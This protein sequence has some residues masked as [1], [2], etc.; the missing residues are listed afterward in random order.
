MTTIE[1]APGGGARSVESVSRQCAVA[2]VG[3]GYAGLAAAIE[4]SNILPRELILVFE[5][6]DKPG[7]NSVMNAGQIAVVGSDQQLIA[8]IEDTVELMMDDM[9]RA[10]V[11]LNHPNL[12][13]TMIEQ[14]NETVEWTQSE[15]GVQY[16]TRVTQLGGHSV[17]RTLSTLNACGEDIIGPMI[18]KVDSKDNVELIL[19]TAFESFVMS[20]D[21]HVLGIRTKSIVDDH[22]ETV[23]CERGVVLASG[24]FGADVAFR[25]VQNPSYDRTVMSTNQPGATAEVMKEALKIGAMSVQLSRIQLGPWTSPDETGFGKVRNTS[26]ESGFHLFDK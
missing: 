18:D 4:A 10:G 22:V 16:R 3:S 20:D 2:I 14:S 25:S 9:L 7:G 6:M 5:K 26:E 12:I 23:L 19:E 8:G 13:R 21:G 17:P 1:S 15:L 11:D 24:G